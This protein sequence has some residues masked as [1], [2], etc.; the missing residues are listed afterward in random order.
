MQWLISIL[1]FKQKKTFFTEKR[2]IVEELKFQKFENAYQKTYLDP[3]RGAYTR[4][5]HTHHNKQNKN[6]TSNTKIQ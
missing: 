1:Q 3:N 2:K 4:C 5:T 6:T